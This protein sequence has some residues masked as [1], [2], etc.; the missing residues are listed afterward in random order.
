MKH[1]TT[2]TAKQQ[3]KMAKPIKHNFNEFNVA[4]A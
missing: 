4:A 1:C 2:V 3:P